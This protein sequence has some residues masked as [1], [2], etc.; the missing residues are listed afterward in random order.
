MFGMPALPSH[1]N[2]GDNGFTGEQIRGFGFLHDGSTD[3]LLR[4]LNI[5]VVSFGVGFAFPGDT[6]T[7]KD[8]VGRK[9]VEQFLFAFDSNLK[10][11]VGQQTTL[12]DTNSAVVNPRIDLLIARAAAG[13]ADLIVKGTVGGESRGWRRRTDALFESDKA[14]EAALTDAALR[15]LAQT[16][17]QTLTYMAVPIGSAVRMGIDRDEDTLLDGDDNCAAVANLSQLDTDSDGDG[18]ACDVDDDGDGLTDVFEADIGTNAL[19]E[20]T[21]GDGLTDGAEVGFDGNIGQY[22]PGQDLNPQSTDTDGDGLSDASDPI[23][24]VVNVGDGDLA[25]WNAPDSSINA[26]DLLI[27][28][29]IVLG[30]LDA[31]EEQLAHGDLYPPGAPDGEITLQDLILLQGLLLP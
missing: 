8:A 26:G 25:P 16:P 10:P 14:S 22:T 31:Q 12:T 29:R 5:N 18:N 7:V 11:V 19:L 20:D 27:A 6:P 4:F 21:D 1:F 15:A 17:G 2:P 30:S 9:Q 24:L 13:D 28:L 3:T 23:P